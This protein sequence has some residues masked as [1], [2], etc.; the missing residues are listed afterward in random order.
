[1]T[2]PNIFDEHSGP[3]QLLERIADRWTAMIIC[4]LSDGPKRY[5]ELRREIGGVS[6][7]MLSQTLRSLEGDG[8]VQRTVY[9]LIPPK[10]EYR[11]TPLGETLSEPLNAIRTWAETHCDELEAARAR[12]RE[13]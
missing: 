5:S 3:R 9:P 2:S 13:G 7:K 4:A 6:H 1:M 10:V 8:L 12:Q 11:L